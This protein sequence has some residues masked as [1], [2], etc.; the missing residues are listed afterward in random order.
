MAEVP[1]FIAPAVPTGSLDVTLAPTSAVTPGSTQLV[2]F[3]VPFPRG[4]IA[5]ADVDRIRVMSGGDEIPAYVEALTPWRHPTTPALDNQHVRVA[6]IQ[7]RV[8]FATVA[9]IPLTVT[10]G[11]AAR[12]MSVAALEA[13]RNGWHPVTSGTYVVSDAVQEPNV[14]ATLPAEWLSAGVLRPGP[15][16]TFDDT[17]GVA[18]DDPAA[19]DAIEHDPG[20][21]E[22]MYAQKN[23]FFSAINQDS[24]LVAEVNQCPYKTDAEPWLY[25]RAA[26]FFALYFRSGSLLALQEAVRATDDYRADLYPPGTTPDTAVGAHRL[27]SPSPGDYIGANDI[28]YSYNESLAYALWLTGDELMKEPIKWVAKGQ[29]DATDDAYRWSPTAGYTE[30]HVAF[31]ILSHLVA[32]EVFGAL[33]YKPGGGT[34]LERFTTGVENLIDHQNGAGGAV[35]AQRVDGALW[36]LGSQQ[37]DGPPDSYVAS[38]WLSPIVVDV[39]VRAYADTDRADVGAFIRRMGTFLMAGTKL[40]ADL[41]YES[42]AMTRAVDYLTLIDGSTYAP[43]GVTGEHALEVA[44]ALGWA[45]YFSRVAGEPSPDLRTA[46]QELY[47]TYDW[48]VNY[49]TRPAANSSG[50]TAYRITPWRKYAWQYRVSNSFSWCMTP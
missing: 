8:Q 7:V 33:P 2:T 1:P 12:S 50:L 30:R 31:R 49:W 47:D 17:I 45:Y 29:E 42:A 27:K 32:W 36:K 6:R 38:A 43:D 11:G 16:L 18:R 15:A 5:L 39:M 10:W 35:P 21:T 28:M 20:F 22:Q 9:P 40:G 41:E 3:G 34:Y 26:S 19:R 25:D 13:P 23:F 48:S 4:S 37:G 44:A 24:P 14:Y 46:A